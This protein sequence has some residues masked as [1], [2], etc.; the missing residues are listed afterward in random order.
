MSGVDELDPH[1]VRPMP[2]P[3]SRIDETRTDKANAIIGAMDDVAS[4]SGHSQWVSNLR[5]YYEQYLMRMPRYNPP[6]EHATSYNP[7]LT[8]SSVEDTHALLCSFVQKASFFTPVPISLGDIPPELLQKRARALHEK[9]KHTLT[10]QTNYS[11]F[12]DDWIKNGCVL[13]SGV[14]QPTWTRD[15]RSFVE[16]IFLPPEVRAK[17]NDIKDF[18]VIA[19]GLS[20]RLTKR[21]QRMGKSRNYS[22]SVINE[23]GEEITGIAYVSDEGPFRR[24]DERGL[25]LRSEKVMYDAPELFNV[26][27][28]DLIVPADV[29]GLQ[30]ARKF[31]HVVHIDFGELAALVNNGTFN[32]LTEADMKELKAYCEQSFVGEGYRGDDLVDDQVD[33]YEGKSKLGYKSRS[34]RVIYEYSYQDLDKDGI[35]ESVI[36]A[37][38]EGKMPYYAM[39]RRLEW[40]YPH[41][42]RPF[43][44]WH[45][46]PVAG[47]YHG[48][49]IPELLEEMQKEINATYWA[50]GDAI[51]IGSKPMG[52]YSSLSGFDPKIMQARPGMMMKVRTTRDAYT[53]FVLPMNIAPLVGEQMSMERHGEKAIGATDMGMGRGPGQP[54]AP[55]TLGGTAIM[56]Q[57]QQLRS[58]IYMQRAICGRDS[59]GG[60]LREMLQQLTALIA[61]FTPEH[62]QLKVLGS[63]EYLNISRQD[64]R[65]RYN[66]MFEFE[67][68]LTNQQVQAQNA[69]ELYAMS[70]GNPLI[71]QNPQALWHITTRMMA[72]MGVTDAAAVLP[73]PQPGV[74]RPQ[75]DQDDEFIVLSRGVDPGVL[76][77]DDHAEHLRKIAMLMQNPERLAML[78]SERTIGL[79]NQHGQ[80]HFQKWQVQ[81]SGMMQAGQGIP[82]PGGSL[83]AGPSP[84]VGGLGD[85]AGALTAP[86]DQ[87]ATQMMAGGMDYGTGQ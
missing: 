15:A 66:F 1:Y 17:R 28:W 40:L 61:M 13:G 24:K 59:R 68:G 52:M 12:V 11:A 69:K 54:N 37:V 64:L 23:A 86:P 58:S 62:E 60:G 35:E 45:L 67:E 49:G 27:P 65:G 57:Q 72:K 21:P 44:D 38:I 41:G 3:S 48:M 43:F 51:E 79:L 36:C 9:L 77:V 20:D 10:V 2:K 6:W 47:R 8:F 33:Q 7:P 76:D 80:A 34:F 25:F 83:P 63:N 71:Q 84:G 78:F 73:P 39:E 46:F 55:R 81:Q 18:D 70:V 4:N 19:F 26:M 56:V 53:P 82:S 50:K 75:M 14:G 87:A 74:T 29:K 31:H 30:T 32:M 22:V 5:N 16:E 85:S 42:R